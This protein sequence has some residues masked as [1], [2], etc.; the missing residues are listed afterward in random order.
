MEIEATRLK[1]S[2]ELI[3]EKQQE[4]LKK[5]NLLFDEQAGSC[6]KIDF[7]GLHALLER[8]S[9][10]QPKTPG[11]EEEEEPGPEPEN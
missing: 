10:D 4:Q 9:Q 7:N 8:I 11:P 3:E 1:K 6:E 5:I 2:K